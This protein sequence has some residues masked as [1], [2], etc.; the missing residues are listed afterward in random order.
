MR[1]VATPKLYSTLRKQDPLHQERVELLM[2]LSRDFGRSKKL[3]PF[4]HSKPKKPKYLFHV[5]FMATTISLLIFCMVDWA[6]LK[7]VYGIEVLPQF[8]YELATTNLYQ[9]GGKVFW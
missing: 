5:L 7:E 8:L 6:T 2:V 9:L 3:P 1:A 4:G